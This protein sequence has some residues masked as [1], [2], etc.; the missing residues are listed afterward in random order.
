MRTGASYLDLVDL[1]ERVG[2][3]ATEDLEELWKRIVFSVLIRNTDDHLR[4]HGLL[5]TSRGWRLSPA[6]DLNP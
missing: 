6:Y 1:I 2:A 5:L 4:N 3:S